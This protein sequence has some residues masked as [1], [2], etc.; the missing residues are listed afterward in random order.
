[1]LWNEQQLKSDQGKASSKNAIITEY[2][3]SK[4]N[5]PQAIMHASVVSLL[6][7]EKY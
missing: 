1:M 3:P 5:T 4:V 6:Q 7:W 2:I